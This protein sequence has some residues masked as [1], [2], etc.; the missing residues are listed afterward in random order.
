MYA[1]AAPPDVVV[2][3]DAPPAFIS[4]PPTTRTPPSN[5]LGTFQKLREAGIEA[6]LH[7]YARGGHGFGM[8][9]RPLTVTALAGS[10]PAVDGRARVLETAAPARHT[11]GGARAHRHPAGGR[12]SGG[13]PAQ[14]GHAG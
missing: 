1:G 10:F 6:E 5:A 13:D 9:Q 8:K 2:P 4:R 3:K 12:A 14:G 11:R 7:V